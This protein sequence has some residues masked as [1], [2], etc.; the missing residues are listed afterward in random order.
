VFASETVILMLWADELGE[1]V[2]VH[3][4]K[5]ELPQAYSRT[6]VAAFGKLHFIR[7][8]IDGGRAAVMMRIGASYGAGSAPAS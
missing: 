7:E 5:T 8:E 1:A 2:S 3:V 6:A 4:E